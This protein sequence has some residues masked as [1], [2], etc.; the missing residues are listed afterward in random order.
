MAIGLD[1]AKV[2]PVR[3]EI[4]FASIIALIPNFV[5]AGVWGNP[6]PSSFG[7]VEVVVADDA[8]DGCWTN[9]G[10]VK[11]YAEDI[12][13]NLNYSVPN[14]NAPGTFL[15][16]VTSERASNGK[17]YGSV[18]IQMYKAHEIDGL[19]GFLEVA[20]TGGI[21]VNHDNANIITLNYVKKLTDELRDKIKN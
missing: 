19:F 14:S 15:I 11:T 8:S 2:I 18:E 4:L 1:Q 9:L 16:G 13:R 10:E 17:C 5:F 3:T 21:F 20:E 12:L 6:S 7:S